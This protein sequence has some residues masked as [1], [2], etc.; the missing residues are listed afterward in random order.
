VGGITPASLAPWHRAGASGFGLGSALYAPGA[1]AATVAR[2]AT[3]FVQAWRRCLD[4]SPP[5]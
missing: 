1:D 3:A 5:D 2:R 4:Q